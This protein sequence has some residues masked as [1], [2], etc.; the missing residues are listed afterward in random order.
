MAGEELVFF[1]GREPLKCVE[2]GREL[3]DNSA[4]ALLNF[5]PLSGDVVKMCWCNAIRSLQETKED[6]RRRALDLGGS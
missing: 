6:V 3:R 2:V 5:A 1:T 4:L